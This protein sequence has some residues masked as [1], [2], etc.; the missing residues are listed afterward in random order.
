VPRLAKTVEVNFQGPL[1]WTQ[2][3]CRAGLAE[4]GGSVLNIA[5][6]GGLAVEPSL[7]IYNATKA[8]LL[9][10]TRTLAKEL[11]PAVRVNAIAPGLVK[12]DM[13]RALWEP[14][15]EAVAAHVPA[16]RLGEPDDIANAALFLS[17]DAASWITGST[18]VVDGGML[19]GS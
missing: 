5:S 14:H 18:L 6:I 3:A 11:A 10:L 9:H 8:A 16:R 2:E 4:G 17:S 7:G 13:A 12:T 1:V 19:L 15:E